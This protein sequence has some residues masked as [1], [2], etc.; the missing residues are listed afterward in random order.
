MALI[1]LVSRG[2]PLISMQKGHVSPAWGARCLL[3]GFS[4]LRELSLASQFTDTWMGWVC[5]EV[6]A[7]WTETP[8][9]NSPA[10]STSL[11]G[12]LKLSVLRTH[13]PPSLNTFTNFP[14][15]RAITTLQRLLTKRVGMTPVRGLHYSTH[16]QSP[17]KPA[18][19]PFDPRRASQTGTLDQK[20]AGWFIRLAARWFMGLQEEGRRE[21]K[22]FQSWS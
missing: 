10:A 4:G 8:E 13:R 14:N 5:L 11:H 16:G 17:T 3:V 12:P 6:Q 7:Q 18:P 9:N 22:A 20:L 21:A 1:K 19:L 15:K 2:E